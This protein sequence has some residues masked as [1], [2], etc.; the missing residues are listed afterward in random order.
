MALG[1]FAV[2][3]PVRA[4]AQGPNASGSEA[5]SADLKRAE[6]EIRTVRAEYGNQYRRKL[7]ELRAGFQKAADLEGALAVRELEKKLEDAAVPLDAKDVV[8]APRSVREAQLELLGKQRDVL[9][10]ILQKA[11]PKLVEAKRTLTVAGRLDE[12]SEVLNSIQGLYDGVSGPADKVANGTVVL[13]EE[14]YLAYQASR[15]RADQVYRGRPIALRGRALGIRPD[16]RDPAAMVLVVFAEVEGG[17][18]DCAFG[19]SMRLREERQGQASLFV[20]GRGPSDPSPFRFQKGTAIEV[21][22]KC[23]GWDDG[24]RLQ[25]CS[26]CNLWKR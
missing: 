13:A 16:P 21:L 22:G 26:G 3:V 12:A 10:A 11:L 1:L 20:L 5:W 7:T 18:V 8:Q 15:K 2:C 25:E 17:F 4:L 6:E 23:E 14:L 19:G 24:L 9:G